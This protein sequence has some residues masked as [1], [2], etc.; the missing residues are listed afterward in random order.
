[1]A[2]ATALA[3]RHIV[4]LIL[5]HLSDMKYTDRRQ[6]GPDQPVEFLVFRPTLVPSILVNKL[7]A[8]EGTSILWRRYPHLPALKDMQAERQQWYAAKVEQLFILPPV[9]DNADNLSFLARLEWPRLKIL[10]LEL[11]LSKHNSSLR[12]VLH[13]NLESLDISGIHAGNTKHFEDAFLP[14]ILANC[15]G[16]RSIHMGPDTFDSND[17]LH[18]QSFIDFIDRLPSIREIQIMN[19]NIFGKDLLFGRLSQS[20]N[21]EALEIDLD[22]GLHLLPLL[23][24]P[25]G[26]SHLF[27]ALRRL[28]IMCYPE[29][30]L[31]LPKHLPAL[32]ELSMDIARIPKQGQHETDATILEELL[33]AL[34]QCH[35]LRV[36]KINIGPMSADFPSIRVLPI[37]DGSTLIKLAENCLELQQLTLLASEPAAIDGS[38]ISSTHFEEFCQRAPNLTDLSMK[39]HPG[40]TIALEESALQSLCRHC[41]HLEV[42]RLKVALQVPSLITLDGM[43]DTHGSSAAKSFPHPHHQAYQD[44]LDQPRLGDGDYTEIKA[45]ATRSYTPAEAHFLN[46]THLAF[47]RPQ[48]VLSI[49]ADSYAASSDL[50]SG[51]VVD[52]AVE[53]ELVRS[54]A[55]TLLLH[56]PR[57]DILEAWSDW[58]GHDNDSLNYFLP[59]QEPLASTWEFLSGVEQDLWD[60]DEP[61]TPLESNTWD[62]DLDANNDY[63]SRGSIDWERASLINEYPEVRHIADTHYLEPYEEEPE[64]MP[65]PVDDRQGWLAHTTNKLRAVLSNKPAA[66]QST[67]VES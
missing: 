23:Q 14:P 57:L 56:F 55:D 62:T 48:S 3:S 31:A 67:G 50:Q 17:P 37:L 29:I 36:L 59:L 30:A 49:A 22:P 27:P 63:D 19:A 2:S 6:R 53:E 32:H 43:P 12:R 8:E 24:N 28:H 1:M 51:S 10:E 65:T 42:L 40:T 46:L 7:W 52:L 21:L 25:T 33:A 44:R 64:D 9:P 60:D 13:P 15:G 5:H 61:E 66:H 20:P 16:I 34:V 18:N 35:H 45:F 38:A 11:D 41:H 26:L 54:W 47:A 4:Y 58:T 39:F